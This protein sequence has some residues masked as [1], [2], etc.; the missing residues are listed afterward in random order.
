MIIP[1]KSFAQIYKSSFTNWLSGLLNSSTQAATPT[2]L[3]NATLVQTLL[4]PQTS[5]EKVNLESLS[6]LWKWLKQTE[7]KARMS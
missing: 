6:R 3:Q 2:F 1:S 5:N 7:E 4:V